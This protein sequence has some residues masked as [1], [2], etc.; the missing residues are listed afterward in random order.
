MA[1]FRVDIYSQAHQELRKK[2]FELSIFCAT[3]DFTE[4]SSRLALKQKVDDLLA[5]LTHHAHNEETYAHPIINRV[6]PCD[7]LN[8]EHHEQHAM[9]QQLNELLARLLEDTN[10]PDMYTQLGRQWYQEFNRFISHYLEHLAEEE[11]LL[12]TMWQRLEPSELFAIMIAFSACEEPGMFPMVMELTRAHLS[13]EE[14]N[15]AFAV[16]SDRLGDEIFSRVMAMKLS[17]SNT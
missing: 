12:P 17:L 7:V 1:E 2:M 13:P 14:E 9:L 3:L 11:A 5:H 16:I 15:R 4:L 8:D 6:I 10:S